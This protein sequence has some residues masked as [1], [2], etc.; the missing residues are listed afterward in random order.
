MFR[1]KKKLKA[2]GVS[3]SESLTI[4]RYDLYMVAQKH[5]LIK[6]TWTLDGR[7]IC[8]LTNNKKI[9]VQTKIDLQKIVL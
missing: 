7:I 3:I 6:S 8:L 1:S 2:S 5:P 9:V 4:K